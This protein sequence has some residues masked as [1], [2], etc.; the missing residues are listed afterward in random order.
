MQLVNE[1]LL[2]ALV[3]WYNLRARLED[4]HGQTLAEYGLILAVVAI[5]IVVAA[6][7]AFRTAIIGAF[8]A[9]TA[10]LSD[11]AGCAGGGGTGP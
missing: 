11:P 6:V 2:R 3:G 7:I 4:E 8:D 10:C 5:G 1:A 9:V